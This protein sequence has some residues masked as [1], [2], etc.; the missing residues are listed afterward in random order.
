MQYSV[1]IY[2]Q[3]FCLT[4]KKSTTRG[5]QGFKGTGYTKH[6][7]NLTYKIVL[8]PKQCSLNNVHLVLW[9]K[10][11]WVWTS[12]PQF[13]ILQK[14]MEFK[15][16]WKEGINSWFFPPPHFFFFFYNRNRVMFGVEFML[17]VFLFGWFGCS[18]VLNSRQR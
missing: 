1:Q 3:V 6:I 18:C 9:E 10:G 11:K 5:W 7:W 17:G 13:A 12:L 14:I 16:L 15:I 2:V 4:I 8:L